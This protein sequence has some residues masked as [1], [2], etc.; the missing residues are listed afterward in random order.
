MT[1]E[2]IK[3]PKIALRLMVAHAIGGSPLWRIE[4]DPRQA[5]DEMIAESVT[6]SRAYT[7]LS[8]E[9][10]VVLGLLGLGSAS[11]LIQGYY[12]GPSTAELFA[13]LLAL[14]DDEV[15]R[16]LTFVMSESLDVGSSSVEAVGNHLDIDIAGY[17]QPDDV[18]FKLLKGKNAVNAILAD[19]AGKT[20]ADQH[21]TSKINDQKAIIR[22]YLEGRNGR[23]QVTGWLPGYM[24]FPFQPYTRN[25]GI[26]IE[27]AW[28]QVQ[29][30]QQA[31]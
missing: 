22:D 5:N 11:T 4:P 21:V 2:L 10:K 31:T 27:D 15:M 16:I 14:S 28:R 7:S 8:E 17:W 24:T 25:G 20:I 12:G 3:H 1:A 29:E 26:R 13:K 23:P 9:L 6:T 19:V 18:F 30:L